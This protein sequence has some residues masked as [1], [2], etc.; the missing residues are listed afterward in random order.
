MKKGV[1]GDVLVSCLFPPTPMRVPATGSRCENDDRA[2]IKQE[3]WGNAK[4]QMKM[5]H[6]IISSMKKYL[7]KLGSKES[8]LLSLPHWPGPG[9]LDRL[10]ELKTGTLYLQGITGCFWIRTS[11]KGQGRPRYRLGSPT[12]IDWENPIG[13]DQQS[14]TGSRDPTAREAQIREPVSVQFLPASVFSQPGLTLV[15]ACA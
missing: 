13:K 14:F 1:C 4:A 10:S 15:G 3:K 2:Q 11:H 9:Y 7:I 12:G 5:R 8:P 6:D